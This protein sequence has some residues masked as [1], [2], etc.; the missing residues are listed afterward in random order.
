MT[1]VFG[2]ETDLHGVRVVVNRTPL[3]P[4]CL[5]DDEIE[6]HIQTLKSE[7]DHLVPKMKRAVQGQ[8]KKPLFPDG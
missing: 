7:L 5:S 8:V 2:I 6:H 3:H 1:K 4:A